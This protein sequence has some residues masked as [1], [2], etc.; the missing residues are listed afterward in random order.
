MSADEGRAGI[1]R[2]RHGCQRIKEI[3]ALSPVRANCGHNDE[4]LHSSRVESRGPMVP[5]HHKMRPNLAP[6]S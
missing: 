5:K 1:R 6:L 2:L 4:N 3:L